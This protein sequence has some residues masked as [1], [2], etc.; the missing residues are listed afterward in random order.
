MGKSPQAIE[1]QHIF[2]AKHLNFR[3]EEKRLLV[4]GAVDEDFYN[5][6][7]CLVAD[8]MKKLWSQGNHS[9]RN[10]KIYMDYRHFDLLDRV[11]FS[12]LG[13]RFDL[14]PSRIRQII[15]KTDRLIANK[16]LR[17]KLKIELYYQVLAKALESKPD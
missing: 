4:M 10:A 16:L 17:D 14:C 12:E 11:S 2:S 8:F 3:S 15:S 7:I 1:G 13:A 9:D 5:V 6:L